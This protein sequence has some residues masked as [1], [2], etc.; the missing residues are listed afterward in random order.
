MALIPVTA[1][2][3]L[4]FLALIGCPFLVLIWDYPVALAL[5]IIGIDIPLLVLVWHYCSSP[6]L[7]F[8]HGIHVISARLSSGCLNLTIIYLFPFLLFIYLLFIVYSVIGIFKGRIFTQL[9]WLQFVLK[10]V[11]KETSVP[12]E[13]INE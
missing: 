4:F 3:Y 7:S 2:A 10:F 6:Q 13:T 11:K 9:K 12:M 1:Y 8:V 5:E